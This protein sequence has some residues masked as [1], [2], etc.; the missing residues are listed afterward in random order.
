MPH[1]ENAL[2]SDHD[3]HILDALH[4]LALHDNPSDSMHV[5]HSPHSPSLLNRDDYFTPSAAASPSG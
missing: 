3:Q 2:P 4:R 5:V 1:S